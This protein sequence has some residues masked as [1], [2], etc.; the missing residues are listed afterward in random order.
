MREHEIV[1]DIDVRNALRRSAGLPLLGDEERVR[2]R[3]A[4]A[5]RVRKAAFA[6]EQ[7]RFRDWIGKGGGLWGKAARWAQARRQVADELKMGRHIEHVLNELGYRLEEDAWESDGRRTYSN[8]EDVDRDLLKDLEVILEGYGW[9]K[10]P[11]IL[12]AF[13]NARRGESLEVEIGGPDTSGHLLHH[14]K[15]RSEEAYAER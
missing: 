5:Q 6:V 8:S 10:H 3:D 12:R 14:L 1:A 7:I 15:V 11:N 9:I 4:R 13:T 2:L